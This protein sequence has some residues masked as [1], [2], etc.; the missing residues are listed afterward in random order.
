MKAG[1]QAA[2]WLA[3]WLAALGA[4]LVYVGSTLRVG[5]DLRLFLPAATTLQQRVL[6]E[7]IG[8]GPVVRQLLVALEGDDGDQ[9]AAASRSLAVRLRDHPAFDRVA[10][11]AAVPIPPLVSEYRYLLSPAMDRRRLDAETLR[12]ALKE[13]LEDLGSPASSFVEPL[14]ASDPTLETL[15]EPT[16]RLR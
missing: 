10:N 16:R 7:G 3:V 4:L 8:E 13:R 1:W 2:S 15:A 14:I 6:L 9:L 12:A 11:G 5:A